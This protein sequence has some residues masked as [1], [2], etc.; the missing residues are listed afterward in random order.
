MSCV[1]KRRRVKAVEH[2]EENGR[3]P[4]GTKTTEHRDGALRNTWQL[5]TA[6]EMLN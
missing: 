3:N 5:L 1:A 2:K 4:R 6:N